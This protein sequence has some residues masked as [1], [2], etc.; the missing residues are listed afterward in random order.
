MAADLGNAHGV[1]IDPGRPDR[2]LPGE[3][4]HTAL[5]LFLKDDTLNALRY[6]LA[7]GI[8]HIGLSSGPFEIVPEVALFI[9]DPARAPV[10]MASQWLVGSAVFPALHFADAYETLEMIRIGA[11]LDEEDMGGPGGAGHR[12]WQGALADRRRHQ[13]KAARHRWKRA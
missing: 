12:G 7:K 6:A 8:A 9:H 4:S 2:G 11:V 1:A 3:A 13:G 10:V 5:A